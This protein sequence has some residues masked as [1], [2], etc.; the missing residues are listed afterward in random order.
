LARFFARTD[1]LLAVIALCLLGVWFYIERNP[2]EI[3]TARPFEFLEDTLPES[4]EITTPRDT[5]AIAI[6][7]PSDQ[8]TRYRVRGKANVPVD[9]TAVDRILLTLKNLE[10]VRDVTKTV[11]QN[12]LG[13]LSPDLRLSFLLRNH[14]YRVSLGK[15]C[16]SP[17]KSRYALLTFGD[18]KRLVV[19]SPQTVNL[20]D[21]S[22]EQL[23]EHRLIDWLPSEVDTIKICRNF[24]DI[25]ITQQTSGQLILASDPPK[26][27][28]RAPVEQLLLALTELK[29]HAYVDVASSPL[30]QSLN[31]SLTRNDERQQQTV[32]FRFGGRCPTD[33]SLTKVTVTITDQETRS[34]CIAPNVLEHIPQTLEALD[35]DAL[36]FLR[37]DEVEKLTVRSTL[38]SFTL[39]R[40]GTAFRQVSP[41]EQDVTLAAGN[42][43]LEA[44]VGVRGRAVGPC[45]A[46]KVS[47]ST[48]QL[49]SGLVG[50]KSFFD[51][52]L[53]VGP[54]LPTSERFVCRDDN[55]MFL[56]DSKMAPALELDP[57]MLENPKL[58]NAS[59]ESV[60]EVTIVRAYDTQHLSRDAEGNLVLTSPKAPSDSAS[61]ESLT[62]RLA[63]LDAE[64][65][66]PRFMLEKLRAITPSITVRFSAKAEGSD[67]L[68]NHELRLYRSEAPDVVATLD[69]K[70]APFV[71]SDVTFELLDGVFVDRSMYRLTE[72]D[73]AF[74][75][76][77]RTNPL[78]C[79]KTERSYRCP[80]STL[81]ENQI[82][83]IVTNLSQL[84]AA[85]VDL[86]KGEKPR[87]ELVLKVYAKETAEPRFTLK[88]GRSP[89]DDRSTL[90]FAEPERQKFRFYYR[91]TD[92]SELFSMLEEQAKNVDH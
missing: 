36:F 57:S 40:Q 80:G 33:P 91:D 88:I 2:A 41:K 47:S 49:R 12:E 8:A 37:Y 62:E 28:K 50:K 59:Y 42:Q 39:E 15:E 35:D 48:I 6:S 75:L 76:S 84:R 10:V 34:G 66:L 70:P 64:R 25:T 3:P 14:T 58:L 1:A 17:E 32:T 19:L 30:E 65:M 71:I 55:E 78:H 43:L 60:D 22:P 73:R 72:Q 87:E 9:E 29:V 92:V 21:V 27:A 31:V 11:T 51:E 18:D 85:R 45:D 5:I 86:A 83:R 63:Q 61:I 82:E 79:T 53:R 20:L 24:N 13:L 46:T 90:Y 68:R 52:T 77:R 74:S 54:K 44:L 56:V 89:G 67:T 26:R 4:L 16:P 7:P 23:I 81:S 38:D 69:E